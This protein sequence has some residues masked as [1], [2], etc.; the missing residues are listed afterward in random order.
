MLKAKGENRTIFREIIQVRDYRVSTDG[1]RTGRGRMRKASLAIA[2]S[3]SLVAPAPLLLARTG[4]ESAALTAEELK[5]KAE[6]ARRRLERT[7]RQIRRNQARKRGVEHNVSILDEERT[8]LN[9]LLISTASRIQE[10]EAVLTRIELR[11]SELGVQEQII[12]GSLSLRHDKIARLLAAMQRI[13]RQP[14]PVI[15]TQR[16]DALKM[17]RSA[18]LLST[19]FPQLKNQADEL[20]GKLTELVRVTSNIRLERDKLQK[21]ALMLKSNRISIRKLMAKKKARLAARR[22]QLASLGNIIKM[23]QKSVGSLAELLARLD[24][25]IKKKSRLGAYEKKLAR[26]DAGGEIK[27]AFINPGRIEPAVAFYK[28]RGILPMP[29]SGRKII[30]YGARNKIG[31]NSKGIVI[32]TRGGAQV[33][34]PC[35][36]WVA[37]A[38]SFRSYG[39][40]LIINAGGGYHVLLAGM[41]RIDASLGQFVLAGEPLGQMGTGSRGKQART[42][43]RAPTLYI[44]FRKKGRPINPDPWWSSG[45]GK[46]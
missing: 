32:E 11:L 15:V 20:A 38:G 17:V 9:T 44:E 30:K 33:T 8:R 3:I 14:P 18:M 16:K 21:Q 46:V 37:Y 2:L 13:G 39:N 29:V 43:K 22:N 19:L 45:K 5:T 10:G 35:D 6:A 12:R 1:N 27:T 41:D 42:G 36:G 23:H 34:A 7:R 24:K 4:R 28:T 25:E 40:L 26:G 31:S